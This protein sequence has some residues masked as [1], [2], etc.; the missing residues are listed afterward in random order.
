MSGDSTD[1]I[2]RIVHRIETNMRGD[3]ES[4]VYGVVERLQAVCESPIEV[5]FG[6]TL[7]LAGML[8]DGPGKMGRPYF[9][10]QSQETLDLKASLVAVVPQ[11]NWKGFRIDFAL[12]CEHL[13][14]PVFIECDGHDF[15]ERTK[16]Q[17]SRDRSKDRAIQEAGIVVLRFTGSEIYRSPNDC[18]AQAISVI[19]KRARPK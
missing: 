8:A 6:S 4:S 15:H 2:D 17:A 19:G 12:C 5:M 13:E 1:E 14:G 10:L 18:A 9:A 3:W 7:L 16:E 11:Y